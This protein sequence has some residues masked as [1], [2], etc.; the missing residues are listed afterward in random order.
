MK[1]SSGLGLGVSVPDC[2][3]LTLSGGGAMVDGKMWNRSDRKFGIKREAAQ[4]IVDGF[5]LWMC[6]IF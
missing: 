5:R 2:V 4:S 1:D 3:W 6:R